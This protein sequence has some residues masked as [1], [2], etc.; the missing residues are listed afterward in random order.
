MSSL[1]T[2][3]KLTSSSHISNLKQFTSK[4]LYWDGKREKAFQDWWFNSV[5]LV[6]IATESD[7]ESKPSKMLQTFDLFGPGANELSTEDLTS[8]QGWFPYCVVVLPLG[9]AQRHSHVQRRILI[10]TEFDTLRFSFCQN[11]FITLS[12]KEW[13]SYLNNNS[14]RTEVLLKLHCSFCCRHY[15]VQNNFRNFTGGMWRWLCS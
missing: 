1:K 15:F 2:H 12:L 6:A 14:H 13:G 10:I 8:E 5:A 9:L 11:L 7:T 4:L 3:R